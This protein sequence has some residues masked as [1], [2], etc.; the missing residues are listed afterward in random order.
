MRIVLVNIREPSEVPIPKGLLFKYN[1]QIIESGLMSIEHEFLF[2]LPPLNLDLI[3]M[4]SYC[5]GRTPIEILRYYINASQQTEKNTPRG[6]SPFQR[7]QQMII[8]MRIKYGIFILP[9]EYYLTQ[10]LIQ[11]LRKLK[12][13]VE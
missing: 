13:E 12:R 7:I 8:R 5:V 11:K 9:F 10:V 3:D 2:P 6:F 4:P 1:N